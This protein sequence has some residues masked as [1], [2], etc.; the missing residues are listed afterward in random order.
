MLI[1]TPYTSIC[2]ASSEV[3][4]LLGAGTRRAIH[5]INAMS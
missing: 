4:G 3:G 5:P 1:R 2:A